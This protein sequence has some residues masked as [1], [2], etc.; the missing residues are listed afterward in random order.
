MT[1][2]NGGVVPVDMYEPAA[3]ICL[4]SKGEF[5]GAPCVAGALFRRESR[6]GPTP[7]LAVQPVRH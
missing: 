6:R 2:M 5:V 4:M 3:A 1:G 7:T